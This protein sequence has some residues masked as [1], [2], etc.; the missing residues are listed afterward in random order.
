MSVITL[1][2]LPLLADWQNVLDPEC[3]WEDIPAE[4]PYGTSKFSA[5]KKEKKKC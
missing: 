1:G 5:L 2:W 3:A 4:A